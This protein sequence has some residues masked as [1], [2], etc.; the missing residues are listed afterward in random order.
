MHKCVFTLGLAWAIA[1]CSTLPATPSLQ[2]SLTNIG[3]FTIA[4]LE[5]ADAIA[6]AQTPPD[7]I[8]DQCFTGLISFVTAQ[9]QTARGQMTVSGAFSVFEAGR[10]T[11]ISS[12]SPASRMQLQ[13]LELACGPLIID[14]QNQTAGFVAAIA[15]LG[16]K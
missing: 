7:L 9:Q 5:N 11:I 8:A 4:D 15:T 13:N 16:I 1:G 12:M 3:K 6:T 10:A 2:Q 14:A